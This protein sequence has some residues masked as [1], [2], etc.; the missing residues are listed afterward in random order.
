MP[1]WPESRSTE[2]AGRKRY[3]SA[4]PSRAMDHDLPTPA[5]RE[6]WED[7]EAD[8]DAT[9]EELEAEGWTTLTLHVGDVTSYPGHDDEPARL[10]VM[11]ADNE[12]DALEAHVRSGVEFGETVV[13]RQAADGVMFLVCVLRDPERE[14]A[15]LFPAFYPQKGKAAGALAD[16][17]HETGR[18]KVVVR[19]LDRRRSV[20]FTIEEPELVFPTD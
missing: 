7:V 8:L 9:A 10:D 4:G 15:T 20:A 2:G 3:P 16:H 19:P 14:V 12:F 11:V 13:F 17:A 1:P 18:L 5:L 6:R